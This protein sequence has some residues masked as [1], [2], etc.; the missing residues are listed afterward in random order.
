MI[1]SSKVV[2]VLPAF[3]A[4]HTLEKTVAEIDTEIVD[5]IILVDDFSSDQTVT[6]A[7]KLGLKTF[8]HAENRGYGANQKTCF[9]QALRLGADIVV[10]LHPDYQYSPKLIPA[11]ASMVSCGE[12]DIVL[13]TRML[14]RGARSGGMPLYK[15]LANKALTAIE[16]LVFSRS[17]SEYH[18]GFRAFSGS[19]LRSM[20]YDLN[21]DDFIFDNQILAQAILIDLNIGEIS[22]PARYLSD[23]SSISAV[24][25]AIYGFGV[26]RTAIQFLISKHTSKGPGF[27]RHAVGPKSSGAIFGRYSNDE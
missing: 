9:E 20:P 22:C 1:Q 8:K 3:N 16:N 2:V 23:S 6:I 26:L 27:L 10:M 24:R 19:A 15:F 4:A 7:E 12:Y 17:L 13:G 5:E 11:M 14:G 21:S 25:S 18:T